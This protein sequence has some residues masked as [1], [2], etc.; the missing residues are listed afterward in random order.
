[1][2]EFSPI[3]GAP[4]K[5]DYPA[6][7][8]AIK[9]GKLP[10]LETYRRL[11]KEDLFFLLVFGLGRVDAN[12]PW[13]VARIREVEE[14]HNSTL[15]LW[16]R[17]HYKS[18]VL[19]YALPIQELIL[20]PEERIAIFSHTRPI[21]K[22]FLRQIKQTLEG[23]CLVKRWFKDV[24]W[25]N[26]RKDAPKWSEDD[27]LLVKRKST[28][29]EASIEAWGLVDGQPTSKHFTIRIYDDVVTHESVTT[30]EMIRK[31]MEAFELSHSLGTDGGTKRVIGTHYHF[32]DLYSELI[33]RGDY[34]VRKY[35]AT[36][37]GTP[38]G[39]P[40]L[41]S[42]QR[43]LELRREQGPYVF[44]CQ[45]LLNPVADE[46][47]RFRSEW[48]KHYSELP[49]ARRKYLLV[50]PAHSK[51]KDSDYSAFAVV[52]ID[53]LG[54]R[55]L[56]DLTRER[57]NLSERWRELKRLVTKHGADMPVFYERYGMLSDIH[58]FEEKMHS[59]G[60]YFQINEM[61]GPVS[62]ADRI[63]RLIPIFEQGRFWLPRTLGYH[64]G[65]D[66]V[67]EFI[68]EELLLWPFSRHDDMLDCISRIE[69]PQVAA[70][71]PVI[72]RD[73]GRADHIRREHLARMARVT[74]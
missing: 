48:I 53:A 31:T 43:L 16:A 22:G 52:S 19:T 11:C 36:D 13:I 2:V 21:A 32:A 1:M 28:A 10:R 27:G 7:F 55:F 74:V 42:P 12:H 18:T 5:F 61:G 8:R 30:P 39:S 38:T 23:D 6:L 68:E 69:D 70:T 17:E 15:D 72:H 64:D 46:G 45:Q 65:R 35:P 73:H 24:F 71:G 57:M 47:R 34:I 58:Y 26:P 56:E 51:K 66:V 62:K 25:H 3:P 37:D 29:K 59:E 67:R 14:Q 9:R 40:V 50:D 4:Y 20:N 33:K 54:N 41:L 60:V 63:E 44:A 49:A